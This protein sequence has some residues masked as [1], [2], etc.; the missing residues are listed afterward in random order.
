MLRLT[1]RCPLVLQGSP[2]RASLLRP[3]ATLY[4]TSFSSPVPVASQ[5]NGFARGRTIYWV[6]PTDSE[7]KHHKFQVEKT[8]GALGLWNQKTDGLKKAPRASRRRSTQAHGFI[9]C[10]GTYSYPK[11]PTPH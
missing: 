7:S 4:A 10:S 1:L 2:C 3:L 11:T 6:L 5:D 8:G 9:M